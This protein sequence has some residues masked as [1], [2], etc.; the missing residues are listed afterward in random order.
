[1]GEA[2]GEDVHAEQEQQYA[3][4]QVI[5]L[6]LKPAD[7]PLQPLPPPAFIQNPLALERYPLEHFC[8]FVSSVLEHSLVQPSAAHAFS[9]AVREL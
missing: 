2:D 8:M 4:C 5:C 3:P 1:M 7:G 6:A 9:A